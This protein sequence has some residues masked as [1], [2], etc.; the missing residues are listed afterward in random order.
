[1]IRAPNLEEPLIVTTDASDFAMSAILSQRI[2]G[3]DQTGAYASKALRGA[4][5]RYCA[6]DQELLAVAF[7]KDK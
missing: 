5:F 4:E 3:K 7:A 2:L 6:Y 1:M